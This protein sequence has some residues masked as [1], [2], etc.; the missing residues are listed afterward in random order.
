VLQDVPGGVASLFEGAPLLALAALGHAPV[1]PAAPLGTAV[2]GVHPHAALTR[3]T[4]GPQ[5]ASARAPT[6]RPPA[7]I[8]VGGA[9]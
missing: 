4:L 5:A 2:F 3:A 6:L 7:A 9:R 1:P 8:H